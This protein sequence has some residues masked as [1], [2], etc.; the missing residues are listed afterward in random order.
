MTYQRFTPFVL[1]KR[2]SEIVL[3]LRI[4]FFV[5]IE[6]HEM[7]YHKGRIDMGGVASLRE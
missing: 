6:K 1:S 7:F 2:T 3:T 4:G 5:F